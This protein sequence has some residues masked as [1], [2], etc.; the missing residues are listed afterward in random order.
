MSSFL[1]FYNRIL[2]L[3][4]HLIILSLYKRKEV[5]MSCITQYMHSVLPE[6][7]EDRRYN[8]EEEHKDTKENKTIQK[9]NGYYVQRIGETL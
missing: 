1:E 3:P 9:L 8:E 5:E 7:I 4:D 6:K 2:I